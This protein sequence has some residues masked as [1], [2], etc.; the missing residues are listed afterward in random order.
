[1]KEFST[2]KTKANKKKCNSLSGF[3]NREDEEETSSYMA[4]AERMEMTR[5]GIQYI[6]EESCGLL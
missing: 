4:I 2:N 5:R 1:L 3:G 6:P